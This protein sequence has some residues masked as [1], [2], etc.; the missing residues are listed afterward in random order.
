M[1]LNSGIYAGKVRHRRFKHT[2]HSFSYSLYMLAIDLDELPELFKQ[3]PLIGEKWYHP[4][5]FNQK[6]Y[7][8]S[9][10]G[11]LR[12]RIENK[13]LELGGNWDGHKVTMVAQGRCLG[14]YF[15]PINFYFCYNQNLQCQYMLA[16]VSNT[17]WRECHYYLV[18]LENAKPIPK[19]F[20]VSPFMEM[21]MD[22]HWRVNPPAKKML[23]H[24]ENHQDRKVFDAT[25]AMSKKAVTAKNILST[26]CSTPSMTLKIV[27]GIYWQAVKLFLKKVPFVAHPEH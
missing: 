6:D 9:E 19:S 5:R 20:H 24:I 16:E 26:L 8:K 7:I 2:N 3:S 14:L 10:L 1:T 21:N 22:Y 12:Q 23:V 11:T 18:N 15:S 4:I 25:L 17:P 13:V 27:L